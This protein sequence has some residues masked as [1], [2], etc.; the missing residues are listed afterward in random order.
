[1]LLSRATMVMGYFYRLKTTNPINGFM[2]MALIFLNNIVV[3]LSIGN[4]SHNNTINIQ[5]QYKTINNYCLQWMQTSRIVNLKGV[6]FP[7]ALARGK[8]PLEG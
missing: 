6:V 5:N 3:D 2:D 4:G 1:M 8:Q 7:R